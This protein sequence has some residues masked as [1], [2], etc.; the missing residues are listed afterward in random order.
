M[1]V[2]EAV[3]ELNKALKE[4]MDAREEDLR[5][6]SEEDQLKYRDFAHFQAED[7]QAEVTQWQQQAQEAE[8]EPEDAKIV[9]CG[10]QILE[11]CNKHG[12]MYESVLHPK[13][14]G[15]HPQNRDGEGLVVSRAF[16]F[17]AEARRTGS[18]R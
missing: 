8:G 7:W 15:V 14:V 5:L 6:Y 18:C 11:V 1:K 9:A 12:M 3:A 13:S 16:D 10:I 4:K 2:A 17:T